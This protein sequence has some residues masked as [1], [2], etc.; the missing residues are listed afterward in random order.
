MTASNYYDYTSINNQMLSWFMKSHFNIFCVCRNK[1][2][3]FMY[4]PVGGAFLGENLC[5]IVHFF[6]ALVQTKALLIKCYRNSWLI[7][8]GGRDTWWRM[9][10]WRP[11]RPWG[12]RTLAVHVLQDRIIW[13]SDKNNCWEHFRHLR[14]INTQLKEKKERT[15]WHLGCYLLRGFSYYKGSAMVEIQNLKRLQAGHVCRGWRGL[16]QISAVAQG[17]GDIQLS[18]DSGHF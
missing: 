12:W 6:V 4:E 2:K 16:D 5:K 15:F 10:P 3:I 7:W 18:H 17:W 13:D 11:A 9:F 8:K 1:K 14:T